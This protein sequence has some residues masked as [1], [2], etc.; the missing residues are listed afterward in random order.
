MIS[1]RYKG[2]H[3]VFLKRKKERESKKKEE[4]K[5]GENGRRREARKGEHIQL[6]NSKKP[7]EHGSPKAGTSRASRTVTLR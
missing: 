7:D 5:D 1:S 6:L 3:S 4:K 2:G